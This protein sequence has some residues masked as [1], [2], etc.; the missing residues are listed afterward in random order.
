MQ[1]KFFFGI[2]KC[3]S[4]EMA[5]GSQLQ[6]FSGAVGGCRWCL[7]VLIMCFGFFRYGV[8]DLHTPIWWVRQVMKE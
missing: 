1:K 4:L 3:R 7:V 5:S 8:F 6:V 2:E